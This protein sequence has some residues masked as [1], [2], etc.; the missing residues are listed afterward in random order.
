MWIEH[1]NRG[2]W[3]QKTGLLEMLDGFQSRFP[4]TIAFAGAG[5]KSTCIFTLA[6]EAAAAGI[7]VLVTTTTQMLLPLENSIL[8][9][10]Q[11]IVRQDQIL[12]SA[13]ERWNRCQPVQI[14]VKVQIQQGLL[15]KEKERF[16]KCKGLPKELW[17]CL[18]E[19]AELILVEADGSRRLPLKFPRQDEPVLPDHTDLLLVVCGL[20][21]LGRKAGTCCQRLELARQEKERF[22][23]SRFLVPDEDELLTAEH[24]AGMMQVGYLDPCK[25]KYPDMPVLPVL[26]QADTSRDRSEARKIAAAVTASEGFITS[27]KEESL[28]F[29]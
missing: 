13:T 24:L 5:G 2:R 18:A 10:E 19:R 15:E 17:Q 11:K 23:Q 8:V 7:R 12:E 21:A 22:K 1:W 3:Q 9:E 4:M 27:L 29:G 16:V 20:S 14:G 28:L 26:N 6:A 25:Q